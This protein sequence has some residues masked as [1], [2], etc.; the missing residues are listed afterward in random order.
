MVAASADAEVTPTPPLPLPC[1]NLARWPPSR[2]R[3]VLRI[4]WVAW[5]AWVQAFV[6]AGSHHHTSPA[7]SRSTATKYT[8]RTAD[9]A[10]AANAY[11]SALACVPAVGSVR[12][13]SGSSGTTAASAAASNSDVGALVPVAH[14]VLAALHGY[15]QAAGQRCLPARRART[16]LRKGKWS[17]G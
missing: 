17:S 4:R 15:E 12:G 14:Q 3:S 16:P 11:W 13:C 1:L 7:L 10:D 2:T 9:D 6:A 8:T 5:C